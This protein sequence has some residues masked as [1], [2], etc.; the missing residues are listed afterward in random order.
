[1][2]NLKTR[3]AGLNEIQK[4]RT[5]AR[6][7]LTNTINNVLRSIGVAVK[8]KLCL[9]RDDQELLEIGSSG[10]RLYYVRG[11]SSRSFCPCDLSTDDLITLG[12][13]LASEEFNAVL[14]N[15]KLKI[16][17]T[18]DKILTVAAKL[19]TQNATKES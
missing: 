1:M 14:Y 4:L 16:E 10:I 9:E 13:Y 18:T 17:R 3:I 2:M 5:E 8:I 11:D 7:N 15:T 6:E 12:E 19:Q